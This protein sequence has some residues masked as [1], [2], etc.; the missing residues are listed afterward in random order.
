MERLVGLNQ[1]K[2]KGGGGGGKIG[3]MRQGS[4]VTAHFVKLDP[5]SKRHG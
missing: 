5:W 4:E 2:K 1:K 3:Q